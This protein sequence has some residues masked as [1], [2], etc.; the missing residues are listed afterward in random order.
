M[1]TNLSSKFA[2]L[3]EIFGSSDGARALLV[4]APSVLRGARPKKNFDQRVEVFG[5]KQAALR[6]LMSSPSMLAIAQPKQ[7]FDDIVQLM[8]GGE[9]ASAQVVNGGGGHQTASFVEQEGA[10]QAARR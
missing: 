3:V 1:Y 9:A 4:Q 7:K 10:P 2:Q 6:Q 5:D 8:G